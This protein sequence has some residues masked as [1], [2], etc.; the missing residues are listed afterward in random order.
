MNEYSPRK[1]E[2]TALGGGSGGFIVREKTPVQGSAR[3]L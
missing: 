1:Y 3:K 2:I